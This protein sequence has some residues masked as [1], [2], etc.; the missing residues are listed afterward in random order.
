MLWNKYYLLHGTT[1]F[2]QQLTRP[3]KPKM[4]A[5]TG[6]PLGTYQ[7]SIIFFDELGHANEGFKNILTA[8]V[9]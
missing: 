8:T 4:F 9:Q 1:V 7:A 3:I 2:Q 5:P 6:G